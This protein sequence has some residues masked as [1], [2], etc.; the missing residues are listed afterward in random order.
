MNERNME[1]MFNTTIFLSYLII[2]LLV[3]FYSVG[4]SGTVLDTYEKQ[5][6][7]GLSVI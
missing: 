5:I 2:I 1:H 3:L 6:I 7:N 4:K